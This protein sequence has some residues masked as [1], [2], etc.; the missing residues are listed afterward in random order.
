MTSIEM[1][2]RF[3]GKLQLLSHYDGFRKALGWKN[4]A[5]FQVPTR[6]LIH[7]SV[8]EKKKIGKHKDETNYNLKVLHLGKMKKL[9]MCILLFMESNL[10]YRLTAH[11]IHSLRSYCFLN[12]GF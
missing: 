12:L 4:F 11:S 3:Q 9:S 2:S 10:G 1:D 6:F 5:G 7:L 8:S